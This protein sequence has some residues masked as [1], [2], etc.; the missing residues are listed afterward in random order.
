M[1]QLT[2]AD[3]AAWIG[4]ALW[5]FF[6]IGAMITAAPVFGPRSVPTRFRVLVALALTLVIMPLLPSTPAV[7]AL[8]YSGISIVLHQVI[9]GLALGFMLRLV[10]GAFELAGESAAQ[11]MGLGF[12]SM[13]D[14]Q[15]G[16]SVPVLSQFYVMLATLMF[17]AFNGHLMWIEVV[18]DSFRAIPV[19]AEGLTPTGLWAIVM[20]GGDMFAWSVRLALPLVA[21]LL[22]VNLSFGVLTR[23]APQLNVFSVGFPVAIA[24]GFVL[25][26]ITLPTVLQ[27]LTPLTLEAVER[28]NFVLQGVR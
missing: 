18:A 4:S 9:I 28:L 25:I 14:P 17:F 3:I 2:S 8:S 24:L 13:I 16:V 20:F 5:P 12:A 10:F 1:L 27:H 6:R 23:A 15:N 7:D 22:V 11:L 19:A 21:A 26:L